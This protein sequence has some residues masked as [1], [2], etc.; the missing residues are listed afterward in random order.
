MLLDGAC[1]VH[2]SEDLDR[3]SSHALVC[4]VVMHGIN[5][6]R[7]HFSFEDGDLVLATDQEE[8]VFKLVNKILKCEPKVL[9]DASLEV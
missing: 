7:R 3:L 6:F 5:Q 8:V 9:H 1:V 2:S 4:S